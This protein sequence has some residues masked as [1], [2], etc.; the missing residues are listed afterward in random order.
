MQMCLLLFHF[1]WV[2][3]LDFDLIEFREVK[4]VI[5]IFPMVLSY[6]GG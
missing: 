6:R 5:R 4:K 2:F 3:H 1:R